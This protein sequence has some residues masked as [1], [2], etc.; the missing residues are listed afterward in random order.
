MSDRYEAFIS[1]R[2][3]DASV[4]AGWIRNRLQRY[5]LPDE[6]LKSLSPEMQE[7]HR[8][9]PRIYLDR[10]YEKPSDDFLQNKLFPA[11]DAS[12]RLIVISSPS[13]FASIREADGI[14]KQ[15]WLIQEIDH[16]LGSDAAARYR[17]IDVVLAPR[18]FE[19]K[20]PGRLG[21]W[22]RWDWIDLRAFTWWRAWG[23]SEALDA[24]FAKLAAGIYNIPDDALPLMRREERRRRRR[25]GF[26]LG[27]VVLLLVG[28]AAAWWNARSGE[29]IAKAERQFD[30]ALR[31]V[32][33]GSIPRA[34]D[35]LARLSENGETRKVEATR[36]LQWWVPRL[37][38]T[39][40][41]FA[42]LPDNSAFRWR[43]RNYV[44]AGGMLAGGYEGPPALMSAITAD[45]RRLITFDSD[46]SLRVRLMNA[47]D[48]PTLETASLK[49][50]P[51][52]ISELFDGRLI[53]FEG[54]VLFLNSDEDEQ[55]AQS[56]GGK[57]VVLLSPEDNSY[58]IAED[59]QQDAPGPAI[60]CATF[61]VSGNVQRITAG[62][63]PKEQGESGVLT[64][65]AKQGQPIEW[66]LAPSSIPS[67]PQAEPMPSPPGACQP[68][69]LSTAL[70]EPTNPKILQLVFPAL[71][72]E[73]L[74]WKDAGPIADGTE[75]SIC[76][77]EK[78][79][80]EPAKDCYSGDQAV[81]IIA[82]RA[83]DLSA[84]LRSAESFL[85]RQL[86]GLPER[87]LVGA[88]LGNQWIGNA[89]CEI[90]EKR[91]LGRC[92]VLYQTAVSTMKPLVGNQLFGISSPEVQSESFQLAD[93][94]ELRIISVTPPPGENLADVAM[95]PSANLLAALT[96]T[97]E[98][99]LYG[100]DRL[101][102]TA[103]LIR[104][105]DLRG[106]VDVPVG[107]TPAADQTDRQRADEESVPFDALAFAEEGRL[108]V[109][110]ARGGTLLAEL[111]SG[112]I[113]WVRAP[114]GSSG[115]SR[116]QISLNA[117]SDL[118]AIYNDKSVQ[119]LSLSSGAPLSRT[120]D[121]RALAA[122]TTDTQPAGTS[123][124]ISEDGQVRIS[125]G[126]RLYSL[127]AAKSASGLPQSMIPQVTGIARNGDQGPLD[128][129]LPRER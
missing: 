99:W 33:S 104:R 41:Q 1:Y 123:V 56:V 15:N 100:V 124:H 9:R 69:T 50:T 106:L 23:L 79:G 65:G 72:E 7:L 129:F 22:S 110:G 35:A 98:V 10:A 45:G 28:L 125:Y 96:R 112:M 3:G 95:S 83:N 29:R 101:K 108:I 103:L 126:R 66:Q 14:E 116:P 37:A 17:S 64:V 85:T 60:D 107:S 67:T 118:I 115:V 68:R 93:A 62:S 43:G 113:S 8:R 16:Y 89:I 49:A 39:P 97:G 63:L 90:R 80:T 40:T 18:A 92:L 121:E 52:K 25:A 74:L 5:R 127:S 19:D 114:V 109:T 46:R 27:A 81:S 102:S 47:L 6:V 119:L 75:V 51:G 94:R 12:K 128:L 30:V 57:F 32:D 44:K 122:T 26:V 70:D 21:D 59:I 24:G 53:L 36:I 117:A 2:R 42:K 91:V 78:D 48:R 20:F 58:A 82:N 76:P 61:S 71:V 4:L 105:Y 73:R 77:L 120:I 38:T 111:P 55:T 54:Q 13:A 86:E 31:L 11:L 87:L 84:I 34:V 88:V